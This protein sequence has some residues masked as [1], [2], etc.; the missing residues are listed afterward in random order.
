MTRP[1]R[2]RDESVPFSAVFGLPVEVGLGTAAAVLSLG[3]STAYRLAREGSFPC[4]LRKVGRRYVVRTSDLMR[5]L[6]IQD[7]RVRHDDFEAGAR[8]ADGRADTCPDPP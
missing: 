6:H 1:I 4:P 8:F 2:H 3:R 7:V 5:H